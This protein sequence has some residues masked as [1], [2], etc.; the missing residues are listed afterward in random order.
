MPLLRQYDLGEQIQ[1]EMVSRTW[2]ILESN[3]EIG[4]GT[5][6]SQTNKKSVNKILVVLYFNTSYYAHR[7]YS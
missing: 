2:K 1:L 3:I 4:I 7:L 5:P 6:S